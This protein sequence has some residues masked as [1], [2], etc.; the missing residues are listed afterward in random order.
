M[1]TVKQI[2]VTNI[3]WDAPNSANL[4]KE[5]TVD[6]TPDTQHLLEDIFGYSE[7]LTDYL[8][9]EYSYCVKG[10]NHHLIYDSDQTQKN[11]EKGV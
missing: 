2:V 9:G 10:Y 7:E 6:I 1:N 8:S 11:T 4:P 3:L 5:I